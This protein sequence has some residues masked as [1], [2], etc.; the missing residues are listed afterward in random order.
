MVYRIVTKTPIPKV[1]KL[2][3]LC[4]HLDAREEPSKYFGGI[5][6][7]SDEIVSEIDSVI[8]YYCNLTGKLCVGSMPERYMG[9]KLLGPDI[10]SRCP[11]L[12]THKK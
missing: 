12:K 5:S 4:M 1:V 8:Q 2:E 11:S 9:Q 6:I 7:G 10:V 3:G